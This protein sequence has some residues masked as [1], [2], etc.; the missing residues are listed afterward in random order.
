MSTVGAVPLFVVGNGGVTWAEQTVPSGVAALVIATLPAWLLLFDW[1]YGGRRGPRAVEVAGIGL[2]LAG[3][4]ILSAPGG[5]HPVGA[6]VLLLS[7]V[8]W[9]IGSLFNR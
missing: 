9:A 7:A 4:A 5:V 3:V 1:G 8:A 2:G 6:A